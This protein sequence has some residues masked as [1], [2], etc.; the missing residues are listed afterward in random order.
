VTVEFELTNTGSRAGAEVAQVY[1]Q[2]SSP[3]LPRPLKELKG[4][5]K[6]FLQPGEK[7]KV[8]VALDQN[9]FAHYDPDKKAWVADKGAYK[10]LVGSSSRDLPARR[11][12]Q[13]EPETMVE[14]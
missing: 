8:S 6:V 1:V 5:K 3:S 13:T 10:I 12:I 9:A 11:Q 7:Q 4:F 2:E 14:K